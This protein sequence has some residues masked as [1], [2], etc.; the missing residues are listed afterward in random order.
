M[1]IVVSG[2]GAFTKNCKKTSLS[3]VTLAFCFGAV[4]DFLLKFQLRVITLLNK[5]AKG[6]SIIWI[7]FMKRFQI[8]FSLILFMRFI[9]QFYI[10]PPTCC[11]V[12]GGITNMRASFGI[13][14]LIKIPNIV[15]RIS[16]N[17]RFHFF[18]LPRFF[19][20]YYYFLKKFM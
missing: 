9:K 20:Y 13:F 1:A 14:I 6:I 4:K 18:F 5:W 16:N 7:N 2:E 19:F 17:E 3:F 8:T 10:A 12:I 15:L 11:R